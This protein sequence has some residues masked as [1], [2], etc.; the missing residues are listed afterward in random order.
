MTITLYETIFQ[1][2]LLIQPVVIEL[3][4]LV[5]KPVQLPLI[6]NRNQFVPKMT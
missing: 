5:K 3:E 4:S 2:V 6:E 1:V